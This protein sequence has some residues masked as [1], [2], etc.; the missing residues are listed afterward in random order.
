MSLL[1]L[2]F[3]AMPIDYPIHAY[4]N[5]VIP[6]QGPNHIINSPKKYELILSLDNHFNPL[7]H[8]QG[9]STDLF[10][11]ATNSLAFIDQRYHSSHH[12]FM[13][14]LI[15]SSL[16]MWASFL[17]IPTAN[18]EF[19]G[20]GMRLQELGSSIQRIKL[21]LDGKDSF[22]AYNR[23]KPYHLQKF[24][25]ID[26]AGVQ[27]NQLLAQKLVTQLLKNKQNLDRVTASVYLQSALDQWLE[28]TSCNPEEAIG[29]YFTISTKDIHNYVRY[30]KLAYGDQT[31]IVSRLK[32]NV[33]WDLLDP[34]LFLSIYALKAGQTV[35]VP[36]LT[37]G[38]FPYFGQ[39]KLLPMTKL[40][41]T[42]YNTLEKQ[43][44][45][46][47]DTD[48]TYIKL[49][50]ALGKES[51]S[52]LPTLTPGGKTVFALPNYAGFGAFLTPDSIPPSS[53]HTYYAELMVDRALLLS[54]K[55]KLGFTVAAWKQPEF[56]LKNP[57]QAPLKIGGMA[58]LH[59][60]YQ[61]TQPFKIF[62][63][64]GYKSQGFV[65]GQALKASALMRLGMTITL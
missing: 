17:M 37:L 33:W 4:Q 7:F 39:V 58:L 10:L 32:S 63:S 55:T 26:L 9:M 38:Y 48:A 29:H 35:K 6:L 24:A 46:H 27:A 47:F 22:V 45:A 40:V 20:H 2:C 56:F 52:N 3:L 15:E 19:S 49:T 41:L 30:M 36:S 64:V 8:S 31:H 21:G 16:V 11:S 54:K 1:L 14:Q 28:I 43:V 12:S 25:I 60:K 57:R 65:V 50:L 62:A 18:H 13:S 44:I 23:P 51:K 53:N 59:L 34:M 61:I 42:P 5:P